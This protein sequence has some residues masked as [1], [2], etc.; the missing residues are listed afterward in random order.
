M[1]RWVAPED[2]NIVRPEYKPYPEKEEKVAR[3]YDCD[4]EFLFKVPND[5]TDVQIHRAVAIANTAFD[6]GYA[7]GDN[8]RAYEIRKALQIC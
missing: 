5:W 3:V 1:Q 4:G 7:L 6:R 8:N 2:V